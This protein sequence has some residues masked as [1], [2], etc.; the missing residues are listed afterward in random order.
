VGEGVNKQV[1]FDFDFHDSLI[2]F[3]DPCPKFDFK[4]D[5]HEYLQSPSIV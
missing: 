5:I 3:L 4:S 1:N 2:T